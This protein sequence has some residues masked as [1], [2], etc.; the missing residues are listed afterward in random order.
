MLS[1]DKCSG[2]DYNASFPQP[3]L[4]YFLRRERQKKRLAEQRQWA[5]VPG[6]WVSGNGRSDRK[7]RS[8]QSIEPSR[9]VQS[10]VPQEMPRSQL[11]VSIRNGSETTLPVSEYASESKLEEVQLDDSKRE[12]DDGGRYVSQNY[13]PM[14]ESLC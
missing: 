11:H 3:I 9:Q 8:T 1:S 12:N 13:I 5:M 4:W 2:A 7:E 14:T 10:D 6:K